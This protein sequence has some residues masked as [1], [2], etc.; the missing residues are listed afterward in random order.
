MLRD[1]SRVR[2]TASRLN[3]SGTIGSSRKRSSFLQACRMIA[4][5]EGGRVYD[6]RQGRLRFESFEHRQQPTPVPA[7]R[8]YLNRDQVRSLKS[9]D[10]DKLVVNIIEEEQDSF[11][12][13]GEQPVTFIEAELPLNVSVPGNS[14]YEL[15]LTA[16]LDEGNFIQSWGSVTHTLGNNVS[17]VIR[18]DDTS[19]QL[20]V[21]NR[22]AGTANGI[23]SQVQADIFKQGFGARLAERNAPSIEQYG[24]KAAQYPLKPRYQPQPGPGQMPIL[25]G[26][27][28][29][30]GRQRQSAPAGSAYSGRGFAE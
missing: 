18:G 7:Q 3:R 20:I 19:C 21:Y 14:S 11:V 16:N 4:V 10:A 27:L 26:F 1:I 23:I 17:V 6:D 22:N 2:V 9:L 30:N 12:T 28:W 15:A 5:L 13:R 24:P 25:A 29:G 8:K